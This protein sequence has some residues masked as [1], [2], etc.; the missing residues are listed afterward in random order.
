MAEDIRNMFDTKGAKEFEAQYAKPDCIVLDS[1]YCSMGRMIANRAC[2]QGGYTYWDAVL[3][4]ELVPD[5]GVTIEDVERFETK[6]RSET[7]TKEEIVND[8]EYQR[9]TKAFDKAIDIALAK[10]PC[11]IHDRATK[12]MIMERGYT[13][14]SVLMYAQ[15]IPA[16][17]VRAKLSPLYNHLTDDAEVAAKIHEEDLIRYNYHKAHSD[18][19]WGKK[20]T[21]D[22]LINSDMFVRDYSA[23]ILACAMKD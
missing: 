22:L 15:D 1:E 23:V 19:E 18:T 7:I 12:E 17:I 8:A 4:L 21:Y 6:L 3:L 2:K 9:I 14:V 5:C 20:E 16:K 11:L 10:G 13:C